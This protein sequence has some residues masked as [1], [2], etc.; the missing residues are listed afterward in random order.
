MKKSYLLL[1]LIFLFNTISFATIWTYNYPDLIVKKNDAVVKRST[2]YTVDVV[3][4][5]A[6]NNC[7]VMYDKN[8]AENVNNNLAKDP[9][10]HWTNFSVDGNSIEIKIQRLDGNP[11][12]SATVYP[13]KKGY[14]A[15][16][17]NDIATITIPTGVSKLQLSIEINGLEDEPLFVFVDPK[18]T[19]VPDIQDTDVTIIDTSDDIT[20]V[21]EKLNNTTTYKYFSP[22]VH[23]WGTTT[24]SSYEGYKL[25]VLEGKKIYLPGG[26]YVIGSFSGND[27]GNWKVYGRGIISGAGLDILST[28]QYIPWSAVHHSGGK[29]GIIV[30]GIVSMCPP[31]FGITIR[32]ECHIDNVK[33]TSWWYSTDGTITGDN[34]TVNNCFFKVNDDAIKVY[35]NNCTHDNNTM[36]HQINGAPFQFSWTGQNS[37]NTTTTNTYIINSIY[38]GSLTS[39][40]NTAVINCREA[41]SGQTIENHVFDGLYIDNGCHRLLGLDATNG[42]LQNITIKNVEI[43]SGNNPSPQNGYSYLDD[44]T[45]SNITL[46]NIT[47]D[48]HLITSLH[49][50]EDVPDEGKLFF[51]G[52]PSAISFCNDNGVSE[53]Q[54]C[55]AGD[56]PE[57]TV[58]SSNADCESDNGSITFEFDDN[59]ER[60][61][62]AF[63][64][65][66][67]VTFLTPV[68]DNS[69]STVVSDLATGEYAVYSKWGENDCSTL[70]DY[71]TIDEN[72]CTIEPTNITDLEVLIG[73]TCPKID[74]TWSDV[75]GETA[76]RI[77][78]KVQGETA[79]TNIADVTANTLMYTDTTA[80]S[81]HYY[82]YMVRPVVNGVAVK[83]SNEVTI[84]TYCSLDTDGDGIPDNQD[85]C[86]ND[87]T[88]T[89]NGTP[90]DIDDLA[91]TLND[92]CHVELSWG[93]VPGDDGYRIRRKLDGESTY[94]TLGDVNTSIT[95]YIDSTVE[96]GNTYIYQVRPLE[97]GVATKLSNLPSVN[98]SCTITTS[99][100][101]KEEEKISVY[102]SPAQQF[103]IIS[104]LT[105]G[106]KVIV[107]SIYG[108]SQIK[109]VR[110][111]QSI[112]VSNLKGGIYY[113]ILNGNTYKF[114][115]Q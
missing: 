3:Q 106:D 23:Q 60:T 8:Q 83:I 86:P 84:S 73:D 26:T 105:T 64:I 52:Q 18:E 95:S 45:F 97:N 32:G 65:D 114:I 68:N 85:E 39:T 104:S 42:T 87:A 38:K 13:L 74:L 47:V 40:S 80:D 41:N 96:T 51:I 63:S 107:T 61:E 112:N 21:L 33:M 20:T 91:A 113:V 4:D 17:Q 48:G 31:H 103:L 100:F 102:P 2:L 57:A 34:S 88:N 72:Q 94:K 115:K 50:T 108:V 7:Y 6:T 78:R 109:T 75:E 53:P 36:Y 43:L 11:L 16:I 49:A 92:D 44:G 93:D 110:S 37:K 59:T 15:N 71:V 76:Y 101:D 27:V 62:I 1:S 99:V 29:T 55:G 9:D 67:G 22:G 77:R 28:A 111:D 24:G 25:P 10:H 56:I 90:T 14:V 46:C 35:G 54:T 82:I 66:G 89:C 81:N 79:F 5:N 30:E 69:G 70:L 58:T 98:V 19:D 12:T